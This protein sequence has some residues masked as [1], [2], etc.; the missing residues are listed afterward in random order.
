[1][2]KKDG[3]EGDGEEGDEEGRWRRQEKK[4]TEKMFME[5]EMKMEWRWKLIVK[6]NIKHQ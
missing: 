4:V 2:E 6:T 3:E 1:M 5:M